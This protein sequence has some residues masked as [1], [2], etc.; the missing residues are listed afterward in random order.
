MIH[1]EN[2]KHMLFNTIKTFYGEYAAKQTNLSN[3]SESC[4][5]HHKG[6]IYGV[7]M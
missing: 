5:D 4:T 1:Q 7:V 2:G 6:S 3:V